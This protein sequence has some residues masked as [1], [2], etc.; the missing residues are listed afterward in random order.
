M[1]SFLEFLPEAFLDAES[2]VTYYEG[3][4]QGLGTKLF[5]DEILD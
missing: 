5:G 1:N 3:H 2:A 4:L